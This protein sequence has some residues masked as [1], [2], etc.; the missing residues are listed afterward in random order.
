MKL[1]SR[2]ALDQFIKNLEGTELHREMKTAI[3]RF[4]RE[5]AKE[6]WADLG[7]VRLD[8]FN[9][10]FVTGSMIAV[11]LPH[12]QRVM[13]GIDFEHREAEVR[14]IGRANPTGAP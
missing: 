13:L 14:W 4:V 2:F 6:R 5:L 1:L 11:E 12:R 7:E 8:S 3:D 10:E 9:V